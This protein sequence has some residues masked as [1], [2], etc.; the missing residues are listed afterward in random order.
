MHT[1]EDYLAKVNLENVLYIN[2]IPLNKIV[3]DKVQHLNPKT[4]KYRTYWTEEVEKCIDGFWVEHEGE[5]KYIPGVLYFYGTHW[6]IL[7]NQKLSKSKTKTIARPYIRDLEW[8]KTYL[9]IEARG[10]SGFEDDDEYTCHR[11]V[12]KP[13]DERVEVFLK[14]SCYNKKGEL[15]KYVPA[16]EYLWKY[17][18]KPLGKA[19]FDNDALNVA[20]LESRGTGKSY[21]MSGLAGH[22]FLFDG[23]QDFLEFWG[24]RQTK[25]KLSSETLIGAIDS[26]YSDDLVKKV[27][28]GLESLE[29]EYVLGKKTYPSPLSKVYS[30]QWNAGKT[31]IQEVEIKTGGQWKKVGSRSKFQHRSFMDNPF[32][33]NGTRA[34]FNILD[35]VGFMGNL[36]E[37]LVQMKECT[38]DSASKFGTIWMTGT[39]GD[40]DGGA[41][42]AV[43]A[44]FYDP[45]TNDC[46]SF[47]DNYEGTN[48]QMGFFVPAWMG[49]NQFKDDLGNTDYKAA[50]H[51]LLTVRAKLAKGKD[52][53]A[54][55]GELSQR[56][57]IPSEV[58]LISGGNILPVGKLK[59]QLDFMETTTEP[60]YVGVFGDMYVDA[61]G[62]IKFRPDLDGKLQDNDWPVKKQ[63]D[64][65]GGIRIWEQPCENPG[66]GYYLAGNDPY[67]QD[68][69]PTS[70]SLGSFLIMKRASPGISPHDMIVAEYTARPETAKDFYHQGMLL[71]KHYN[72]VGTCLY[73]NEKIGVKTYLENNNALWLLAPTPTIMKSNSKSE[74]NRQLGQ[75]MST[76]VKEECEIFLRDWLIAPAGDNKQ[77]YQHIYSK[78]LLKELINY[79]KTGNFDRVI[80]LMLCVVQLTQMHKVK[81]SDKKKEAESDPFFER[82]LFGGTF[83]TQNF[84]EMIGS[85][86]I[87]SNFS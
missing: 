31:I 14:P 79:N 23:A 55:N 27:K 36:Q 29:G 28:L 5:H 60:K 71:L 65:T 33:A 12:A 82:P 68:K 3:P 40:M 44:V 26:K 16:R 78:P 54:Y 64:H 62:T 35:E 18:D 77:N 66:Y 13:E 46:V 86:M 84:A 63:S 11:E 83:E 41:T 45:D 30:G 25:E 1:V 75:H 85:N 39:G 67:D 15:K 73:E 19:L 56:P 58:F 34:S 80:A 9:Y 4:L 38:A 37:A 53:K 6:H 81:A 20:D 57:I 43:M 51:Y 21:T 10:F 76:P 32:A 7:L 69:A 47:E 2:K 50:I 70:V 17:H 59:E 74:T 22:N 48:K 87:G 24:K 61:A 8:I 52:K 72:T 42:M 49:L